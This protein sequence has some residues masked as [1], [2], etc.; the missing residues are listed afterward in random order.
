MMATVVDRAAMIQGRDIWGLS[1]IEVQGSF[2]SWSFRR[3]PFSSTSVLEILKACSR[4]VSKL[5]SEVVGQ[6][7]DVLMEL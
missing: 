7:K 1:S 3:V 5:M 6:R 4:S 2:D